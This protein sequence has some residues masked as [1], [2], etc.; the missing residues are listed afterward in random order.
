MR[1]RVRVRVCVLCILST[2]KC[3]SISYSGCI[4]LFSLPC[5]SLVVY[6]SATGASIIL[7]PYFPLTYLPLF[8][9]PP[10]FPFPQVQPALEFIVQ[11]LRDNPFVVCPDEL[12]HIK[13]RL[14]RDG[15]EVKTKPKLGTID[16]RAQQGR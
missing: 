16:Y 5:N 12:T 10:S 4:L 9:P 11:F 1:V 3:H 2:D 13:K 14:C 6:T 7:V 15:D 8:T